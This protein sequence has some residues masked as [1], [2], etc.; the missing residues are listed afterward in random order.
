MKQAII[1]LTL[2]L[3]CLGAGAEGFMPWTDIM[4]GADMDADGMVSMDEVK[5]YQLGSRFQGF[6]PWMSDHFAA[7]DTD[8]DGQVSMKEIEDGMHGMGMDG[9]AL[10]AEWT[11]GLGFMPRE[12]Q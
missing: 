11:K 10:S 4:K 8:G 7:L 1:A 2:S 6:Q 9:N 12:G 5:D 3:T